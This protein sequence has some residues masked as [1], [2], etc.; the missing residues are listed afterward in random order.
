ME[1]NNALYGQ[2]GGDAE[3]VVRVRQRIFPSLLSA[4]QPEDFISAPLAHSGN[5]RHA[6]SIARKGGIGRLGRAAVN[7]Q[8]EANGAEPPFL[9]RHFN[10]A[11]Y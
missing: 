4:G 9:N 1:F 5:A 6:R 10:Y 3:T 11:L 2:G 8:D 7:P